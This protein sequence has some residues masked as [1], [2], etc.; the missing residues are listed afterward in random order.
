VSQRDEIPREGAQSG[1]APSTERLGIAGS[2]TV[3]CGL[4]ACAVE[5]C[6]QVL[7]WARS[8]WSASRARDQVAAACERLD[9]R[10]A[11]RQVGIVRDIKD[12]AGATLAVE[13]VKEDEALKRKVL[14]TLA[15]TLQQDAILAS[16]TSSLPVTRLARAAGNPARFFGLHVFNPVERMPLVELCFPAEADAD[17]RARANAFCEAIGKTGVEVPDERGFVVNRLLFPYLFDAVRLLERTGLEPEQIDACMKLG[18]AH[19]M[20]PL[21][22]LDLVGIDVA[23]AIGEA[24]HADTGN[25]DHRPPERIEKLLAEGRLGRKSGAGFYPY[26]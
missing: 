7:I 4:A 15:E 1:P 19:P 14:R 21:E 23:A 11:A 16:T 8:D 9:R 13:A 10:E 25:P 2:G 5:R 24:L 26:D 6:E 12:L 17:T 22:L 20:G 3:A 18:A